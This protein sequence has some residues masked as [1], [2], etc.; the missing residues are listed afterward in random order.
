[1]TPMLKFTFTIRITNDKEEEALTLEQ[2]FRCED[3][4]EAITKAW[5]EALTKLQDRA[6]DQ[7]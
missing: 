6:S 4:K 7:L 1:M 3:T 5:T 2:S